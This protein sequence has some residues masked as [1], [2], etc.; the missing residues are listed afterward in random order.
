MYQCDGQM[1]IFDFIE[2]EQKVTPEW[3]CSFTTPVIDN[4]KPSFKTQDGKIVNLGDNKPICDFSGHI[5][6]KKSIWEV[7]DMLDDK[8]EC[9]HICCRQCDVQGCGARCNGSQNPI[10]KFNPLEALALCGTGFVDGMKRVHN[11]FLENHTIH[12]KASFLKKEYGL[13]GF[14]SPIKKQCYIHD[15]NTFGNHHKDIDFSY[16]DENINDIHTSCSWVELA[17][18]IADMISKNKYIYKDGE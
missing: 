8:P 17:K 4:G 2:P 3:T 14:G 6:N 9:P 10:N 16:Y 1:N 5:C 11:Y 12:E 18:T 13:G 7:A 15:M